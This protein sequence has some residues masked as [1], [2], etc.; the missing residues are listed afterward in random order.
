MSINQQVV[1]K[2]NERL[3]VFHTQAM[4]KEFVCHYGLF[5]PGVKPYLLKS[6]YHKL[7]NDANGSHT[8]KEE[9]TDERVKEAL[10][11]KHLDII[12]D[13]QELNEGCVAKYDT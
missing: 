3:P 8:T 7:T 5:M 6:I 1:S 10:S 13:M 4:K 12:I 9:D 2:L 11:S